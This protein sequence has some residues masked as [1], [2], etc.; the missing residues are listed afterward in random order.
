MLYYA[1]QSV[2]DDRKKI[3]WIACLRCNVA[4]AFQHDIYIRHIKRWLQVP[5]TECASIYGLWSM[6]FYIAAGPI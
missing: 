5:T 1:C 4:Q 2:L 6:W 3:K